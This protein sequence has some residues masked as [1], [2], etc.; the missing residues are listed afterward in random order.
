MVTTAPLFAAPVAMEWTQAGDGL[1][2][3]DADGHVTMWQLQLQPTAPKQ[4]LKAAADAAPAL[5]VAWHVKADQ[6]Q[7]CGRV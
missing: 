3:A 2:L 4:A 6:L 1:L 5:R 7:V